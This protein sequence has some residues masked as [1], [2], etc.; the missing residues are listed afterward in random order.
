MKQIAPDEVLKALIENSLVP[1]QESYAEIKAGK[2]CVCGLSA[3]VIGNGVKFGFVCG[4]TDQETF[5]LETLKNEGFEF[6]Y[7]SGFMLGFDGNGLAFNT[8]AF[9][10]GK[11][12]GQAAW[13]A[14]KHMALPESEV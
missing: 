6:N 7:L 5:V 4:I 8:E 9:L 13:E 3:L 12:D 14:V 1:I 11:H 2:E 10:L